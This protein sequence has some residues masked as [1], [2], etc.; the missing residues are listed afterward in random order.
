MKTRILIVEDEGLIALDLRRKLEQAGYD[1]PAIADNAAAAIRNVETHRP[2]L[3][4]MDIRL[5]GAEDGIEAADQI[6]R[7]FNVPVMFVTAHADRAT[8]NRARIT[9]PFGYIVK[10]FHGVDFGAQIEIALWKHKM[11]QKLRTSEAWLSATVRNV[12]DALIATDADGNIVFMNAPAAELTGWDAGE[13]KGRPLL[14]VFQIFEEATA[15]PVLHPIEAIFAGADLRADPRAFKLA[16]LGATDWVLVEASFSANRDE[17]RLLGVIVVF[18]D[19]TA[20]RKAE[21][22]ERHLQKMNSL[23]LLSVGL[24]RELAEIQKQIDNSLP[25]LI[26]AT[27]GAPLRLLE[28]I[29]HAVAHQQSVVQ[30]L[31]ML[32]TNDPGQPVP[33]DLNKVLREMEV[34][35]RK[36]LGDRRLFRMNLRPRIPLISADPRQLRD[37]LNRLIAEARE[38]TE[39]GDTVEITTAA[40]AF[41]ENR[42]GVQLSLRDTGKSIRPFAKERVFDPYYQSRPG[43]RNPGLSLA[44]LYQFVAVNNG[45]I[46]VESSPAEG[47]VYRLSF[48][49]AEA[50]PA[51]AMSATASVL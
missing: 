4:L 11:E 35:F 33:L 50:L 22:R 15:L 39:Q 38:T 20:R 24:G 30:Q 40:I 3:V 8:L 7:R 48:P 17:G 29:A 42:E 41:S 27:E 16:R 25:E 5:H 28:K 31:V 21:A 47:S 1:V 13:V 37:S 32:G 14:E 10:P 45:R 34:P 46:D 12:A 26:T 23:S 6:R 18:R 43:S 19:I 9:E 36:A 2:D 51:A 44:L 49:A